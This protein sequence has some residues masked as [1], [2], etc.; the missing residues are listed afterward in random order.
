MT[1]NQVYD[2]M[3]NIALSTVFAALPVVVMLVAL[4]FLH[5][6]A[7]WAAIAA[8]VVAVLTAT[9]AFGM[10]GGMAVRAA[11]LGVLSGLFP[12]GWIVLNI[13]FLYR[14]TVANGT[15]ASNNKLAYVDVVAL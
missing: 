12:I 3:G 8:L 9:F 4:A 2:P 6:A 5:V 14:L 10:P 1:W 13:I 7:H 11:G 15:G